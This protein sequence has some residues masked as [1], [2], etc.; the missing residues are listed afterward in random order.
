MHQVKQ[1]YVNLIEEMP[2]KICKRQNRNKNNKHNFTTRSLGGIWCLLRGGFEVTPLPLSECSVAK[3][4][5]NRS[6]V[7]IS[8]TK[9]FGQDRG[10]VI[11]PVKIFVSPSLITVQNLVV[12]FLSYRLGVCRRS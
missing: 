8:V 9:F 6:G 3:T 4:R 1:G 2:P 7:S 5:A 10:G 12:V 11:D